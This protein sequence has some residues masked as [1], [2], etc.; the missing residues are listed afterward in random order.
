M[1]QGALHC[2]K[3][4]YVTFCTGEEKLPSNLLAAAQLCAH[5]SSALVTVTCLCNQLPRSACSGLTS[6][7]QPSVCIRVHKQLHAE[8]IPHL[9]AVEGQDAFKE[10]HVSRVDS[11]RLL[12]PSGGKESQNMLVVGNKPREVGG[13]SGAPRHCSNPGT[14]LLHQ[15]GNQG[16]SRP[17]PPR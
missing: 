8:E 16:E 5:S 17:T 11:H 3:L 7:G 10:H 4:P 9:L 13:N 12:F 1:E 2:H 6:A 15:G 14:S